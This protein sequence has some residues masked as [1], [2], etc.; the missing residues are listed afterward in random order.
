MRHREGPWFQ[1]MYKVYILESQRNG[2]YYIGSTKNLESRLK[3]HNSGK[4]KLTRF[5]RPLNTMYAEEYDTLS[6]ARSREAYLK[7]LKSSRAL[8][9]LI[10]QRGPV[11]QP[12]RAQS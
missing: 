12:V 10:D 4:V 2:R 11:A 8:R 5:I 9:E 6:E 7:K 1:P 3:Q